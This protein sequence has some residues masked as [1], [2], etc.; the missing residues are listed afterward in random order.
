MRWS[1]YS[2]DFHASCRI[3][4]V[5]L[6]ANVFVMAKSSSSDAVEN[7]VFP[8]NGYLGELSAYEVSPELTR[9][10]DQFSLQAG[11]FRRAPI[12]S[13]AYFLDP[14][15]CPVNEL[16]YLLFIPKTGKKPVPMV[17]YFG[18]TG[19]QGTNLV[20]QFHQTTV[21]AKVTSEEF[22]KR[23]PCYLFAPMLPKRGVIRGG[24]PER[25]SNLSDLICDA[26][27][28]V[29]QKAKSPPVDTNRLYLTGLSALEG[30]LPALGKYKAGKGCLYVRRLA[31]V[32]L[33]VLEKMIAASC[34][35]A[36]A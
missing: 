19:E 26:M 14:R 32:D 5:L 1:L 24:L 29:I 7:R 18:G 8:G 4:G 16:P 9:N 35:A 30:F 20:D 28:A 3:V 17:L 11:W 15:R 23:H 22:Q 27:Y 12:H 2:L 13:D 34:A 36:K 31:D 6:T 25:P 33:K 21:F 10:V